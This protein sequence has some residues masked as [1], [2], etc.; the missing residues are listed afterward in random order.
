MDELE[1][2]H[3]FP[4]TV[5]LPGRPSVVKGEKHDV[6][7]DVKN[8]HKALKFITNKQKVID[9][10][11]SRTNK[12]R[13]EIVKA[14]KTAFDCDL[15]S[16]IKKKFHGDFLELLTALLTPTNEFYCK[17]LFEALNQT[18]TDED[19]LIQIL[20]TVTN[21]EI[22]HITQI[23]LKNY[24]KMLEKDLRDD[25]SGN[26]RKILVAM[27]NGTRDQSSVL[28][29][30]AARIDAMEI[31]RAG[32][33]KWGTDASTFSRVFCLRNF[34][35]ISLI[36][37]EYEFI[38]GHTLEK[39]IKKEF[40]GEIKD[41]LLAILRYSDN[42]PEFFARCLYKSMAGLGTNDKS[43]IRLIVTRCEI[44]M[45]DIKEEFERKYGKTLK[46]FIKGD[47]S[48]SYRKALLK[49]IGE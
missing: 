5:L 47:T 33:D 22:D 44:D 10:L 34:C 36:A 13:R 20:V 17:E 7:N 21:Q 25:T 2:N 30:Y 6:S 1:D 29:L 46:S 11:C 3:V 4:Q 26:F 38:T 19:T 24:G 41:T 40:S 39:D 8:L 42:Q 16:E 18:G 27:S 15:R 45:I 35:Q 48:G 28:D 49:L 43:L 23:Y 37:Q 9:I 14:Y 31:K 12:Q 32:I